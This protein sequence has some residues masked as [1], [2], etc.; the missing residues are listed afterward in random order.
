MLAAGDAQ[1]RRRRP[2]ACGVV[3]RAGR[4][5]GVEVLTAPL[6]EGHQH[7]RQRPAE[8]GEGVLDARRHLGEDLAPDEAVAVQ[9]TQRVGQDLLGDRELAVQMAVA[10]GTAR[11]QIQDVDL[12]LRREEA[13]CLMRLEDHVGV[14]EAARGG[15]GSLQEGIVWTAAHGDIPSVDFACDTDVASRPVYVQHRSIS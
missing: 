3:A 14:G 6:V 9:T 12:P 1:Q 11:E 5:D 4:E 7:L 2:R 10:T 15:V 13:E 8:R